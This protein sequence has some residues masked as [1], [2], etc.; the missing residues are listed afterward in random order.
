M[1][2]TTKIIIGIVVVLLVIAGIWYGVSQKPKE[3]GVIRIGVFAPLTG[4]AAVYG[5]ALKKGIDL[6][7]DDTNNNGGVLGKKIELVY[8]DTHLDSNAAVT[9]TNKFINIDKLNMIIAA[10]GSGATLAAVPLADKTK[11]IMM[12]PIASTA[13]IRDA[14]DYVF[15]VIP[16]DGYRGTEMANLAMQKGYKKI[17]VLY[18][19]DAYGVGINNLI[20]ETF[21]GDNRQVVAEESFEP[22][23]KDFR[24]Q[25]TKIKAANPDAIMIEARK[26]FPTIL[27]QAKELNINS[28]MI[29]SEMLTDGLLQ[30]AGSSAEGLMVI[31]FAPTTDY[32]NFKAEYKNK[33]GADPAL[34]SDYGYDSLRVLGMAINNAGSTDSTKIKDVLYNVS[35]NG[36]T[37]TVKFDSY[38]ETAEK[39]F[40]VYKVENG[41][42]AEVK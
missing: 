25:L 38:G 21:K 41:K 24:T 20:K 26:E 16:S 2:K 37:G 13:A 36:A 18:V 6:A 31:D 27:K 22:D 23:A 11:T 9:A 12:V 15:R 34:Y 35:Y 8:E 42:L 17:A 40:I 28:Q 19:N 33:Y 39:Q 30:E 4:D 5:D 32:V 1:N 3:M 14:G 29:A 7:A 10:E